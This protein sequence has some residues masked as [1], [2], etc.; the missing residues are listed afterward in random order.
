MFTDRYSTILQGSPQWR[1]LKGGTGK[2][3][4]WNPDSLFIQ[5]P[6]YFE[7]M[8]RTAQPIGDI[9]AARVLGI[10]GDMLTTD[11]ISPIGKFSSRTPAGAYLESLGIAQRDF[12]NYAARRLNHQV[13]M[14]GTFANVRL[15]NEMTPGVEG[16]STRHLPSGEQMNIFEAAQRY[17]AEGVPLVIVA[18]KEYGAGSSRDWAAKGTGLLGVRAVIAESLERIHRANLVSMGVLPLQFTGGDSRQRLG[19]DGSETFDIVG[20]DGIGSPRQEIQCAITRSNGER[21]NVTLLARLDSKAEIDYYR[22][23]GILKY[24]LRSRL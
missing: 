14:R 18:G 6:P 17:R 8:S 23:G 20:L 10:F 4:N 24:V 19:L 21:L 22:H 13:M 5:R 15:H 9:R 7:G 11:H 12:V 16:S 1:A 2:L 3:Y